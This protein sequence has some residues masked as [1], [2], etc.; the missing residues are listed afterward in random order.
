MTY[1]ITS[2]KGT[3]YE[4]PAEESITPGLLI[5]QEIGWQERGYKK[6]RWHVT[7][8]AST[9]KLTG[10][11]MP[12]SHA[13]LIAGALGGLPVNWLQDREHVFAAAKEI[14]EPYR[15]WL[16]ITLRY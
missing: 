14:L 16:T 2:T 4:V 15:T 1:T 6:P 5:T 3:K 12:K 11:S 10:S 13:K 8:A 7:H 9:M